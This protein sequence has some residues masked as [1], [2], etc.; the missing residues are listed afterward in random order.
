LEVRTEI[1]RLHYFLAP[2]ISIINDNSLYC[3]VNNSGRSSPED[4][5]VYDEYYIASFIFEDDNAETVGTM[6]VNCSTPEECLNVSLSMVENSELKEIFDADCIPD[7]QNYEY[8]C[9]LECNYP[10]GSVAYLT[11]TDKNLVLYYQDE[12]VREYLDEWYAAITVYHC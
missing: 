4:I 10:D 9:A 2:I 8:Y 1:I 3:A 6:K 11:F 7:Y 5:F 12:K